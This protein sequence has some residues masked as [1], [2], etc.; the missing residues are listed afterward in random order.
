MTVP[1]RFSA[2]NSRYVTTVKLAST[3]SRRTISVLCPSVDGS[4]RTAQPV[5][6]MSPT[7]RPCHMALTRIGPLANGGSNECVVIVRMTRDFSP[8]V[9]PFTNGSYN[10]QTQDAARVQEENWKVITKSLD[11]VQERCI[12]RK[13]GGWVSVGDGNIIAAI[14]PKR[15]DMDIL[16]NYNVSVAETRHLLDDG[17]SQA[18]DGAVS[19]G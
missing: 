12:N 4:C 19:P 11:A 17:T 3:F 13:M 10:T 8:N 9:L 15:S 14:W 7:R 6:R 1:M 18:G 5:V 16:Y 2:S